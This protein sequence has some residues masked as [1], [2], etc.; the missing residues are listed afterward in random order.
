MFIRKIVN[1]VMSKFFKIGKYITIGI[2][3][4]I[5]KS[6]EICKFFKF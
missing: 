5:G 1:I 3:I 2:F 4:K 6:V